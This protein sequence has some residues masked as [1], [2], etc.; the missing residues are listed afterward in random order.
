VRSKGEVWALVFAKKELIVFVGGFSALAE[1][2]KEV[3]GDFALIYLIINC[4][5]EIKEDA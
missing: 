3:W 4:E 1:T 2:G 5:E